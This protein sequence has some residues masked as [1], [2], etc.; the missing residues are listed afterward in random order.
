MAKWVDFKTVRTHWDFRAILA[1]HGIE[2]HGFGD[3]FKMVCPFHNDHRP[4][5][6]I[7]IARQQWLLRRYSGERKSWSVRQKGVGQ[8]QAESEAHQTKGEA[9]TGEQG[10]ITKVARI[11]RPLLLANSRSQGLRH[12]VHEFA[13]VPRLA[14]SAQTRKAIN[15]RQKHF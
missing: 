4:S 11:W 3:Q 8:S 13:C 2:E 12:R 6:G 10:A 1:H 15:T 7:N 9:E 14:P 5:C